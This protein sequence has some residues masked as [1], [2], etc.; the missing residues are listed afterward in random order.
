MFSKV[1]DSILGYLAELEK[2]EESERI[3]ARIQKFNSMGVWK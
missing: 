1:K 2:V 3:R